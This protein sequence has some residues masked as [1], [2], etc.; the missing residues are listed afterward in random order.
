MFASFSDLGG[1][2]S[3]SISSYEDLGLKKETSLQSRSCSFKIGI[4]EQIIGVPWDSDSSKVV[5][6]PSY[7]LGCKVATAF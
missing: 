2:K 3:R 7:K 6:Q 4:S 5:L 1:E